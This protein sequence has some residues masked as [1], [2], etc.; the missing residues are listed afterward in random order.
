MPPR[1]P[2]DRPGHSTASQVLASAPATTDDQPISWSILPVERHDEVAHLI[3]GLLWD[4]RLVMTIRLDCW[5]DLE[6]AA[7]VANHS[8][9]RR[10]SRDAP[11]AKLN[12]IDGPAPTEL[13]ELLDP[14]AAGSPFAACRTLRLQRMLSDVGVA[15]SVLVYQQLYGRPYTDPTAFNHYMARQRVPAIHAVDHRHRRQRHRLEDLQRRLLDLALPP[16]G[17]LTFRAPSPKIPDIQLD[18]AELWASAA[19][20]L[21]L[22]ESRDVRKHTAYWP[23][24]D[25]TRRLAVTLAD[26]LSHIGLPT[27]ATLTTV[28][29][30]APIT[31]ET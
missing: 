5:P 2:G 12:W 4:P 27:L 18:G 16:I 22:T 29:P 11:V 30:A 31:P 15:A 3:P 7:E 26:E 6:L 24:R 23:G 25:P 1:P 17:P 13:A 19:T 28:D 8:P 20:L 10:D 14:A 9:A 21:A